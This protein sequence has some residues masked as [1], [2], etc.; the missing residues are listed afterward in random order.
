MHLSPA[1]VATIVVWAIA[2]CAAMWLITLPLRRFSLGGVLASVVL[3]GTASSIGA[4]LGSVRVM[5][6]PGH[7]QQSVLVVAGSAGVLGALAAFSAA[8]RL[9]KDRRELSK[10]V[11]DLSEGRVPSLNGRR[12]TAE[13]EA[14]RRDLSATAR[15]LA[16][17]RS[18]EQALEASRRELVAWVSHDLR[19]PLAG[20]RAMSEALED[21]IV[22]N[23]DVYYKQIR[24]SVERL[25]GMVDDLFDLSRLQAGSF[26]RDIDTIALDDLVS[27][28]LAALKPLAAAQGVQLTGTL[29]ASAL[30]SGNGP[31]LN[32]ALTNL[33]AN[34][35]QHTPADGRVEVAVGV[36]LDPPADH[37]QPAAEVVV[38]DQCGGIAP[39]D[40]RRVFEVGFRGEAARTP[41]WVHP[42]GAGLG[43]AITRGIVEA[44]SGS[45]RIENTELGCCFAVCLPLAS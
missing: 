25:S 10:A 35:I 39:G 34:A 3:T 30:V 27:D 9:T 38:R 4:V 44:H 36:R 12:L 24:A 13:L 6:L 28:C 32:R 14:V 11:T 41:H 45:I 23:P 40:L 2:A 19:T 26:A 5:V 33:V 7:A 37:E 16:V 22:D 17:S 18:R 15:R 31:E 8:R 42:A 20:L 29:T 21:G 1:H 43:L